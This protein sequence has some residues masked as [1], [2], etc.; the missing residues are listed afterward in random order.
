MEIF[1]AVLEGDEG[2]ISKLLDADP[3]L[4][5]MADSRDHMLLTLA[6]EHGQLGVIRLL[7]QRGIDINA[8]G[9]QLGTALHFAAGGGH[10][11]IVTFLLDKGAEASSRMFDDRTPLIYASANGHVGVVQTLVQHR[12]GEGLEERD[13]HGKTA[14]HHAAGMGHEEIVAFLLGQG[15]VASLTDVEG[16]TPLMCGS[17]DGHLEV[18]EILLQHSGGQGLGDR[19]RDGCTALHYAASWGY[20]EVVS[21]LLVAGADPTV[22][23]NEGRTPQTLAEFAGHAGCVEVFEVSGSP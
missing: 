13:W 7:L 8:T 11:E 10:E 19:D 4:L 12:G 1:Q 5:G 16:V 18:V 17:G 22:T 14:L 23:D 15:A 20:D 3:T 21:F 6:A 2:A 9:N